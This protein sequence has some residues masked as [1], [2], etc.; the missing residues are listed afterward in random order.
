MPD[1]HIVTNITNTDSILF[2]VIFKPRKRG[3][4]PS[5][6][7]IINSPSVTKIHHDLT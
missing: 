4:G 1:I 7:M 5:G 6:G 3:G 2:D